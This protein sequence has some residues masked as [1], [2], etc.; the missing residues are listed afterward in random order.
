MREL[1]WLFIVVMSLK[2][3][4]CTKA[5]EIILEEIGQISKVIGLNQ[6]ANCKNDQS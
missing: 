5:E 3:I 4:G 6:V 1:T 2:I